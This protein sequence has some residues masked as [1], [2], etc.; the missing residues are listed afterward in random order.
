FKIFYSQSQSEFLNQLAKLSFIAFPVRRIGPP[1]LNI[2][3]YYKI[4]QQASILL[5]IF[6]EILIGHSFQSPKS[7]SLLLMILIYAPLLFYEISLIIHPQAPISFVTY[8]F[9]IIN[10]I[11]NSLFSCS[12]SQYLSIFQQS[13]IV[14]F[15]ILYNFPLSKQTTSFYLSYLSFLSSQNLK[16]I[17]KSFSKFLKKS[18]LFSKYLQT[19]LCKINL[20]QVSYSVQ[21]TGLLEFSF[22]VILEALS[23]II[24]QI[25]FIAL[26]TFLYS[27]STLI[28]LQTILFIGQF[29]TTLVFDSSIIQFI[30]LPFI[31]ITK[32][33]ILFGTKHKTL[34][35]LSFQYFQFISQSFSW[36]NFNN[37]Y[38]SSYFLL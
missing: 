21:F 29:A 9:G 26:P 13:L 1:F 24:Q 35:C 12:C 31:P 11:N 27:P 6:P 4:M 19:L 33:T 22:S 28:V 37:F 7:F 2:S 15:Q 10:L 17:S 20:T 16:F 18:L 5:L 34:Y 14:E 8:L 23:S 25:I 36:T 30:Y 32:L 38:S 3:S